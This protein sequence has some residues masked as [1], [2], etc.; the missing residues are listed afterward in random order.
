MLKNENCD[1]RADSA[2]AVLSPGI[3]R[4]RALS[5][6]L[7]ARVAYVPRFGRPKSGSYSAVA[8]WG[9]RPTT[10]RARRFAEEAG[11]AQFLCLEDGFLRSV[12]LGVS[13]AAPLSMV[14]DD[15]GIYYD[16]T[17]PSRLEQ[18]IAEEASHGRTLS[19]ARS[20][21]ARMREHRLSKYNHAPQR[22]LAESHSNRRV[23]VVDQTSGDISVALGGAS[24][25]TFQTTLDAARSEHPG[26]EIWI[27][28]HPDVLTGK[29]KGHLDTSHASD[30][31]R[32]LAEDCC[33]LS[34]IEQFDHVYVV[35]SQMGFEA[36]MLGKPVT[37]FGRPWYAGWGLTDDRH[38]G[39]DELKERRPGP[40]TLEQLFA[41]AYLQYARYIK[42]ATGEPGTLFDVIDWLARNKAINDESRGTYYCV[43][44]SLW[45]RAVVTPFLRT[46]S[47]RVKFVRSMR[48]A[49]IATLPPDARIVVWGGRQAGLCATARSRAIPVVRLEDGFVRSAG[50]GSNL[51]GPLSLALDGPGIYYDPFSNS[52][53]EQ[54]LAAVSLDEEQRARAALLRD[55]L[56]RQK[57]NKYNVGT[58]FTLDAQSAGRKVVLVPGQVEDDASILVGSPVV[59]RNRD[60]LAAVRKTNPDAWIV[61]KPHPDVVAGNRQ[62][63]VPPDELAQLSNQV[64][65]E[66]NIADCIAAADE[67]HTMTSLAGFE[68]VLA[69]KTV[70][71][72]GGPFYAG[73]GL[74]VDHFALPHRRR[75]LTVDELVFVALCQYP[76]YRLPGVDGFCTVEDVVRHLAACAERRPSSVGNHWFARQWRK[77]CHLLRAFAAPA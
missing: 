26:A 47:S 70:H 13:G 15:I 9:R 64:A 56:V 14:V 59:R 12:G 49:D 29:K 45:K 23:L 20:A 31:V 17:S 2:I 63:I 74:T 53:L 48:E 61:Y 25:D 73:W 8:G 7:Q 16:A 44:M 3:I 77:A 46:P 5:A 58:S 62:G 75:R 40:R 67:V 39:M 36:L 52:R 24:R 34:L 4:I 6:M 66:A 60:L 32:I 22:R 1:M 69:G 30:R 21:L 76:R 72:Y 50:L 38:P 43:G 71:C 19:Q 27:K 54:L 28:T 41:A 18:C 33:P 11:I 65:A 55:T 10:K 42:P 68:S 51:H 37:V 35:T 57:I